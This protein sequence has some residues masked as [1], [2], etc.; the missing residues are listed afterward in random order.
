MAILELF[1]GTNEFSM[2]GVDQVQKLCGDKMAPGYSLVLTDSRGI[3]NN[4]NLELIV[5]SLV[6]NQP[7]IL[8]VLNSNDTISKDFIEVVNGW[9]IAHHNI[10]KLGIV[11]ESTTDFDYYKELFT[12][13]N[14]Q[15][16]M[17]I[18]KI[19]NDSPPISDIIDKIIEFKLDRV[20]FLDAVHSNSLNY[21]NIATIIDETTE[22]RRNSLITLQLG[23]GFPLCMF[24]KE[25]LGNIFI[26]PLLNFY[27]FCVSKVIIKP[28]LTTT[29]CSLLDKINLNLL[30]MDDI[31]EAHYKL[32]DIKNSKITIKDSCYKN[33]SCWAYKKMCGGGCLHC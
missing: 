27:F 12:I 32:E 31:I 15:R 1:D 17:V 11:I 6:E 22:K 4:K 14:T 9:F 23:C 19:S 10:I 16:I 30:D 33:E 7:S 21:K 29:Y 25:Q 20:L 2:E 8:I 3:T 26:S 28:D 18:S 24:T 13:D 5:E